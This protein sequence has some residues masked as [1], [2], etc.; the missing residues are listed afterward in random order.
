MESKKRINM[1]MNKN[2]SRLILNE[3]MNILM[4]DTRKKFTRKK[5]ENTR[6]SS[7][8]ENSIKKRKWKRKKKEKIKKK[9]KTILPKRKKE[10]KNHKQKFRFEED[11]ENV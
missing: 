7:A 3:W 4:N 5:G 2:P 8:K 10:K 1:K 6:I 9:L 11:N